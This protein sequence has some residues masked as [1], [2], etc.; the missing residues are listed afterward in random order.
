MK[1]ML[2]VLSEVCGRCSH[3]IE[4]KV[5]CGT[6]DVCNRCDTSVVDVFYHRV[7]SRNGIVL[8]VLLLVIISTF[9]D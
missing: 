5:L 8:Y 2:G 7:G 1:F 9:L 6:Y 4:F 3:F